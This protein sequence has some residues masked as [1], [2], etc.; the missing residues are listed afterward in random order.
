MGVVKFGYAVLALALFQSIEVFAEPNPNPWAGAY[1]QIGI[2]GYESYI[3]KGANGTTTT[4]S[5]TTYPNTATANHANGPAANVGFGYNFGVGGNYLLG[6]GATLYPGP[7]Q[8]SK[9]DLGD[10][11]NDSKNWHLRC[12]QCL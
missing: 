11:W 12:L 5:G 4:S 2:V 6:V 9:L 10:E 3:P 1:G 7:L 8:I